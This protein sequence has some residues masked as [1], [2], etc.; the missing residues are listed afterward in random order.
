MAKSFGI[1][2][3]VGAKLGP[4]VAP[5]FATIDSKVKALSTHMKELQAVSTKSGALV[6]AQA[7]MDSVKSQYALN[8]TAALAKEVSA[9]E[10]A[11]ASAEKSARRY[12]VTVADAAKVHAQTTEAIKATE[13]ALARQQRLQENQAKRR[14]IHGQI[15]GTLASAAT[16]V[17]PVKLAIDFES[18]MA[19]VRKVTDF[20][21]PGFARFSGDLLKLSTEVPLA[22]KEMAAIAAVAARSVDDSELLR[23]TK[24]AAIMAVAFDISAAEAGDAMAN[25]RTNFKLNQD[26]VISLGDA[27]NH[28]GNNMKALAA[29]NINFSNRISGTAGLYGFTGQQV[30]ALGAAFLDLGTKAEVGARA[31]GALMMKLG[32]ADALGKDAQAAFKSLGFSGKEMAKAF[33][34]DANGAMLKFLEAVQRSKNPVGILRDVVGEG[35]ADDIGKL[36][37]G[38]DRYHLAL[39]LIGQE[40]EIAGS[41]LKEYGGVAGTTKNSLTLV[42]N[43]LQ[44]VGITLGTAVLPAVSGTADALTFML[45]PVVWLVGACPQLTAVVFGVVGALV[46]L[47][48][49][50]LAGAYAAT[51]LSDGWIYAKNVL[52]FFRPS[53]IKANAALVANKVAAIAARGPVLAMAAATK[54]ATLAQRGF[55]LAFKAS[56][57]GLV[58]TGV[59]ALVGGL[60]WLYETCEPVRAVFDAVFSFIGDKIEWVIDKFSWMGDAISAVLD[61]LGFGEKDEAAEAERVNAMLA[62]EMGMYGYSLDIEPAALP[63][64][65]PV[66]TA[67]G[68]REDAALAAQAALKPVEQSPVRSVD[69]A[70]ANRGQ[71]S[72]IQ[73][74][75]SAGRTAPAPASTSSSS[76]PRASA[77][78]YGPASLTLQVNFNNVPSQ[79]VG[80]VLLSSLK[81]QEREFEKYFAGMLDRVAENQRRVAYGS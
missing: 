7:K 45:E 34:E 24:D 9:A 11:Y 81:S 6:A 19:D 31:A 71:Q 42:T 35:F 15:M 13:T 32:N 16:V 30:G 75:A 65:K 60:Y 79:D 78:A 68:S 26:G 43:Q 38:L 46:A 21:A 62:A 22:A 37:D 10:K 64:V 57:I 33:G 58:I 3:A 41:M 20:D 28:L 72:P 8:P 5:A 59:T 47:K 67:V 1:N 4:S 76:A 40:S 74:S 39:S 63:E 69:T 27:F 54:I 17:A 77:P 56:P 48:V 70:R 53:V 2:F 29:D 12:N 61:F 49:V 73:D 51:I 55:N 14:E 50:G 80:K 18:A 25:M 44:R 52:N 66:S 36:V 23:F